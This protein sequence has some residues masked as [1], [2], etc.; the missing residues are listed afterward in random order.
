MQVTSSILRQEG[1]KNAGEFNGWMSYNTSWLSRVSEYTG[2]APRHFPWI[3]VFHY[4]NHGKLNVDGNADLA[5][6]MPDCWYTR[7]LPLSREITEIRRLYPY[8][9]QKGVICL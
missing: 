9:L 8:S 5:L 3:Y 4:T 2:E 1:K 7:K 6:E